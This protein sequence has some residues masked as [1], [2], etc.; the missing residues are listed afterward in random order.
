MMSEQ[1]VFVIMGPGINHEK[2]SEAFSKYESIE[3]AELVDRFE[4]EQLEPLGSP[5]RRYIHVSDVV[6]KYKPKKPHHAKKRKGW[7]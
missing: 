5:R 2:I 7:E 6:E 3:I 1:R 4:H